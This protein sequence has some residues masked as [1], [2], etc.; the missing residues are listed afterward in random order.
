MAAGA[1]IGRGL[2]ATSRGWVLFLRV[3]PEILILSLWSVSLG[4]VGLGVGVL[5]FPVLT[6]RVHQLANLARA[7]AADWSDTRIERP[8]A[9]TPRFGPHP[10]GWGKRTIW[11]LGQ[12]T[13]WRDGLW[14]LLDP[15][16]GATLALLPLSLLLGGIF[17][18]LFPWLFIYIGHGATFFPFLWGV[19]SESVAL[20]AAPIGA[21]YLV[22][23]IWLAPAVIR[24]HG[25]WT[26][27]LL[28]PTE[29]ARLTQRVEQL[30][31]SRADAVDTQALEIRRIERDL[32]DGAQARLVEA[33]ASSAQALAEL[34]A[35]VRGIHPPVLSD[36]GLADAVRSLALESPLDVTVDAVVPRTVDPAIESAVYFGVSELLTNAVKHARAEHGRIVMTLASGMLRAVIVDDGVGGADPSRGT[37]LNGLTRRLAA[38]DGTL[39]VTSPD[40]GPTVATVE[41]PC[42][43]S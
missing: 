18:L 11:L 36:R 9:L 32:H 43:S 38:F 19:D 17:G 37:G 39:S 26:G 41:V 23:G 29:A 6:L 16:V 34:R 1:V 5:L 20:W 31:S 28:K 21:G 42:E 10:V 13:T 3:I 8:Y 27:W 35:L 12:R 40:G 14:L 33:R 25:R 22:L 7:M 30:S 15:I 4:L 2:L 24:L